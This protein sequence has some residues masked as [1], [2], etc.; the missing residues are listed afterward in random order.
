[1]YSNGVIEFSE[2]QTAE[3]TAIVAAVQQADAALAAAEAARVRALARAG[4]LA[5]ELAAGKPSRVREHDMALRSIA[6]TIGVPARVSDRSMQRQIGDASVLAE[7]Y[8]GTL[9]A[10]GRG[11]ITR[12]HVYAI[13]DAAAD[14]PDEAV[15]AFEAEA[16]E[17]CRR[18]TV[19]RVK[20]EL[21]IL[22][23]RMHPRSFAERHASARE[24]R[25]ITTG[26]L[27]D[28]MS[29]LYL[30]GPTPLIAGIDDRLNQVTTGIIDARTAAIAAVNA[31]GGA[32]VGDDD[33]RIP[34]QILATDTRTRAQI[35]ADVAVDLLLAG[36]P[37]AD[38]TAMGDGP[39]TL[40]AIRAKIQVVV[41][42]LSLLKPDGDENGHAE[43]AD[44]VGYSPIDAETARAIAEA[45]DTWWERLVTHPVTGQVL[46]TN[47][48]Q[49]TAAI[50]RHLRARDRHCRFPGCRLPAIRCEVDHTI[51]H[52]LGGKTDVCNL[53]HLCQR[54]H[55]MKQFAGWT[56]RQ[57]DGGI[58][59][60]TSP[61]GT[62][63]TDYP[64]TPGVHFAPDPYDPDAPPPPDAAPADACHATGASDAPF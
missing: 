29:G 51:D 7:R 63:Y 14:L 24:D 50:D 27:P 46:H 10:R 28:G 61:V 31:A 41:P 16:L 43:P 18:D 22:A 15:A 38:P 13:Q 4:E 45:C 44:L 1:M 34:A 30:V 17:R 60:W 33:A 6:A 40:G 20:A 62:T 36:S 42:A 35:R 11:E 21:E 47:G 9:E 53:A 25:R 59:E 64:P 54:H 19:G 26:R 2:A 32:P 39:G 37:V 48:Y 49:R 5:R 12:Q 56:V 58:L 3:L 8:P 52:A 23:Q 55:S 57:L